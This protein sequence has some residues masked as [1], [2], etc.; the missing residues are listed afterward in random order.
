MCRSFVSLLRGSRHAKRY[1]RR[2]LDRGVILHVLCAVFIC[3]A[4]AVHCT[5][6]VINAVNFT[7]HYNEEIVE[8]NVATKRN[9]EPF[10]LLFCTVPGL[11]GVLMVLILVLMIVASSKNVRLVHYELFWYTHHLFIFFYGLLLMHS[12]SGVLKEQTNLAFHTPG[13]L[14]TGGLPEPEPEPEHAPFQLKMFGM[15]H[16]NGKMKPCDAP[17]SFKSH[18]SQSWCFVVFPL[19]L[20][21]IERI[22]RLLRGRRAVEIS[23]I[24]YHQPGVIE[25]QMSKKNFDARPGQYISLN[26]PAISALEWHP[27]TLTSCPSSSSDSFSVHVRVLGDWTVSLRDSLFPVLCKQA[28][29]EDGGHAY[30]AHYPRLYI[31][32][33]F[34]SPN[35]DVF[36]YCTSVCIAGGVGVTPY[37]AVLNQLRNCTLQGIKLN[38]LYFIWVCRKAD[39]LQWFADLLASVHRKFW[40]E[41]KPDF[42]NIRL[43]V[44]SK[45]S[46]N[47]ILQPNRT[48]ERN[49]GK[50]APADT[51]DQFLANRIHQGR[52][53]MKAI[54]E[55]VDASNKISSIGLFVCGPKKLSN[56]V[57]KLC[58]RINRQR[59]IKMHF[60][61]ETF[62]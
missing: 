20:Y 33:P 46:Q 30:K 51:R 19:I 53:D 25:I 26:C 32:G 21:V 24:R 28:S 62:S 7:T 17:P 42:L 8:V 22:I 56:H 12:A 59:K 35:Q 5:A 13:C 10:R 48:T 3:L 4:A 34:G 50:M 55:E 49:T 44:T 54:L 58:N 47:L 23:N 38:R 29:V 41:N 14:D 40:N 39:S 27:F 57:Q 36:K 2:C 37:A 15:R 9:E 61:K 18:P 43:F 1:A 6:H 16:M 31:D 60:N 52:P 11:T 45:H